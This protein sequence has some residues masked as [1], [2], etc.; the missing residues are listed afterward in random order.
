MAGRSC[1]T[2]GA[3]LAVVAALVWG[4]GGAPAWAEPTSE[5][6][7]ESWFCDEEPAESEG[8]EERTEDEV[9]EEAPA[10]NDGPPIRRKRRR[11]P[12]PPAEVAP[13]A[14][15]VARLPELPP[16][17]AQ[18]EESFRA[19]G[20]SISLLLRNIEGSEDREG[21]LLGG[22]TLS[23]RFRPAEEIALDFGF[24]AMGGTDDRD[25]NRGELSAFTDLVWY[26]IVGDIRPYFLLGGEFV[27][28]TSSWEALD[29][30]EN[31]V[32]YEYVAP[33][34]GIGAEIGDRDWGVFVDG[35]VAP[36]FPTN[37]AAAF[38]LREDDFHP[39]G[40][41]RGGFVTYW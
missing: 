17:P 35:I 20:L 30:T 40:Q 22:G 1:F 25:R 27:G 24:A 39:T 2:L 33:R 7:E 4:T 28:A 3:G 12:E 16:P 36:R 18:E 38:E 31:S 10:E 15:T 41:L 13:E 11:A 6:S 19:V 5:C 29:G 14:Q 21:T 26:P 23:L 32:T 34:G 37:D 9:V 8:E